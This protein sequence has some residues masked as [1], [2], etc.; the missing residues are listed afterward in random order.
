M[1]RP[2]MPVASGHSSGGRH[3]DPQS[4]LGCGC[5]QWAQPHSCGR[6]PQGWHQPGKPNHT[7]C[8][9]TLAH[10]P[11][12]IMAQSHN[13][14]RHHKVHLLLCSGSDPLPRV[15]DPLPRVPLHTHPSFAPL[16]QCCCP[17]GGLRLRAGLQRQSCHAVPR[18][19]CLCLRR[20]VGLQRSSVVALEPDPPP[21]PTPSRSPP[22]P[23]RSVATAMT[24]LLCSTL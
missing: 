23:I 12:M 20:Q 21:P 19:R 17:C 15:P 9:A 24:P 13:I 16:G 18:Q 11:Q 5:L 1:C 6:C 7:S 4:R 3:R 2:A 22:V 14:T 8:S 10:R